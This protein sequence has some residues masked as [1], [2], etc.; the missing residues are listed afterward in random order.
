MFK[1]KIYNALLDWKEM[2]NGKYACLI[3]G[4]RRVGKSTVAE[5]FAK[6]EYRS[7]IR[8]DFSE[9]TNE[10]LDVFSDVAN[11]DLFFNRLQLE[12]GITLYERNS[13][14]VFDEVQL[15]PKARQA[16]KHLVADGRYDYIETGS[17]LSIK[18]NVKG[19][20]LP[21]EEHKISMYPMDYEEFCWAAG[22]NYD[23]IREMFGKGIS[24]GESTNRSLMRKYRIYLAVGGMPQAVSA[25]VNGENFAY[26]DSVKREIIALYKDDL[27]KIDASGYTS[28]IFE[29]VPSQL[30]LK[31]KRFVISQATNKRTTEKDWERLFDLLNS[32]TVIP[33]YHVANPAMSLSQ[34][35]ELNYF[36]LYL[37]D[38]GLFTTMLFHS[39]DKSREDIYK[40][41]LS[42]KLS[43]D[44]GYL[45][46]NAVAQT[47]VSSGKTPYYHTWEKPGSTHSYEIDFLLNEGSKI[48]PVEVKSAAVKRHESLNEFCRKYSAFIQNAYLIS[49]KDVGKDGVIVMKPMY[50]SDVLMEKL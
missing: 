44:A 50:M 24:L 43:L 35:K 29:S 22:E 20:L 1:R 10:M 31:R 33:C 17:L 42:D 39:S 48:S 36:K 25:Y 12:T 49:S 5:A 27:M 23:L 26:I 45:Y 4:A 32:K 6:N 13:C 41:L 40:K 21:S 15:F 19:I 37:A 2:Y 7:Y 47:I 34:T 16:I 46:E 18:K 3:E 9:A 8:V 28:A 38:V 30:A 11:H 14:I